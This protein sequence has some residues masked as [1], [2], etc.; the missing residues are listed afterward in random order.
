MFIHQKKDLIKL[1]KQWISIK[2]E[3]HNSI[4]F[5]VKCYYLSEE[6]NNY[7]LQNSEYF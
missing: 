1:K 4:I 6:E 5:I 3:I 2:H 7:F